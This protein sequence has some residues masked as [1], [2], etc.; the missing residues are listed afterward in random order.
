M[1]IVKGGQ[2]ILA[3]GDGARN[4]PE[5]FPPSSQK[6]A[7]NLPNANPNAGAKKFFRRKVAG[8]NYFFSQC[9]DKF[10]AIIWT[11]FAPIRG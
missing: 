1:L 5:N 11:L 3:R 6:L 9:F 8:G 4:A 2:R 10:T 7:P